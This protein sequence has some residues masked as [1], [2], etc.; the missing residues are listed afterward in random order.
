MV[1]SL[2]VT[3]AMIAATLMFLPASAQI[4]Y[5]STLPDGR[6]IYGDK[7]APGAVKVEESKP[8]TS[9]KGIAPPTSREE[10]ALNTLEKDRQKRER[11]QEKVRSAEEALRNAEAARSSGVEPTAGERQGTASGAQR[12]TDGY[13]ERQKKLELDVENAR[14]AL[15]S[16]RSGK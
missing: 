8:D 2:A 14:R 5:K 6:V 16:A 9:K 10:K 15:E 4:L 12:F 13:W 3:V 1:K 11:S 7:P